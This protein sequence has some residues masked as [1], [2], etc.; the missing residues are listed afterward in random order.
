LP[1]I[2]QRILDGEVPVDVLRNQRVGEIKARRQLSVQFSGGE[3]TL[4]PHFIDAVRYAT[5]VG[6]KSIQVA[7]NGIEFAKSKDFCRRAAEAGLRY[8]D[9]QFDGV[10]NAANSHRRVGNLFDV[11]LQSTANTS[12]SRRLRSRSSSSKSAA[13]PSPRRIG[14]PRTRRPEPDPRPPPPVRGTERRRAR[15]APGIATARD[16]DPSARLRRAE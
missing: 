16:I 10:G 1:E 3:P 14:L 11:K 7:S 2:R 8:A 4:S 13:S 9:L 5:E 15:S 6:Y 12:C